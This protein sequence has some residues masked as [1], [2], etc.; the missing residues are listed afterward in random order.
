VD[1]PWPAR[2]LVRAVVA[3]AEYRR[4]SL[5]KTLDRN[6]ELAA[7]S[8][9]RLLSR[10]W[11]D[12]EVVV[13]DNAP[14]EGI[15]AEADRFSADVIVLGWRGHGSVRRMLMGSV[16]RGVV[17]ETT[18]AALVVRRRQRI[19]RIVV[20][21]DDSATAPDAVAFVRRLVPPRGGRVTLVTALQLLPV[22]TRGLAARAVAS[23]ARRANT[24]RI[25][26]AMSRLNRAAAGLKRKGWQTRTVL[27]HGEPLRDLL[28][29]VAKERAELLAVGA[30]GSKGVQHLLLGSVAEG[31]LNYSPV[32]VV[33][34]RR[35]TT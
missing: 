27:T 31:A 9:R 5:L 20:G 19:R 2:T 16:S 13:A 26:T 14:V 6:S 35:A 25:N 3:R 10:R 34:A 33:V 11:P 1:F 17:R 24:V 29:T 22:P 28:R 4:S 15:L 8:A 18:S 23:E 7:E 30:R 32:P 21:L 12:V